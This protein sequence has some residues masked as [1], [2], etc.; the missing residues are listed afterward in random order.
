MFEILVAE[1][2]DRVSRDQ[3]DV[4]T[5]YKYLRFAG[6]TVVT[7][8]EGEISELHVGLKGTMNALFLKDLAAKTHR[9]LRD[10]VEAGK[11]GCGLCY[12]YDVVKS[13]DGSGD[14]VR[15]G[16]TVNETEAEVVRRVFREFA[17]GANT[18]VAP[19]P[20]VA[21][22]GAGLAISLPVGRG[23]RA[24]DAEAGGAVFAIA[25]ALRDPPVLAAGLAHRPALG[26]RGVA[27]TNADAGRLAGFAAP[28]AALPVGPAPGL[29]IA[30]AIRDPAGLGHDVTGAV[31]D[32]VPLGAGFAERA[33]GARGSPTAA[34]GADPGGPALGVLAPAALALIEL[35]AFRI[36]PGLPL[37]PEPGGEGA[38]GSAALLQARLAERAIRRGRG[39]AAF[40]A[41]SGPAALG[42]ALVE[43]FEIAPHLRD[44]VVSHDGLLPAKSGNG[45]RTPCQ[46]RAGRTSGRELPAAAGLET[47][48]DDDLGGGGAQ[49][50]HCLRRGRGALDLAPAL[51]RE[52][53]GGGGNDVAVRAGLEPLD[54]IAVVGQAG[55]E[56]RN[57][58]RLR[59][60]AGHRHGCR[61]GAVSFVPMREIGGPTPSPGRPTAAPLSAGTLLSMEK[62]TAGASLRLTGWTGRIRDRAPD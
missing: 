13:F 41:K 20:L 34:L 29:G 50:L 42:G 45:R 48:A 60:V 52:R 27:A 5:L 15:G 4:A 51:R 57:Q 56:E 30:P 22:R 12:G 46:R 28:A 40:E 23:R 31:A 62:G 24:L 2:L 53:L 47:G 7:L 37:G 35:R 39:L 44:V 8:A 14:P 3:A 19:L 55:A 58:E 49:V 11:S 61:H 16:R 25:L 6:V 26:G 33:L 10:R 59:C 18:R 36:A 43:A 17:D 32:A 21:D 38:V 54:H 1:A 9:G